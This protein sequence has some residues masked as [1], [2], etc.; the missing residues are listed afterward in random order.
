MA[1]LSVEVWRISL[2]QPV[3]SHQLIE[4]RGSVATYTT[5]KLNVRFIK[6]SAE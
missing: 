4:G 3:L 2:G 1:Q 5:H 6:P